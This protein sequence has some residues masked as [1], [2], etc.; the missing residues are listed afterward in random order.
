MAELFHCAAYAQKKQEMEATLGR[1]ARL[2][3][4]EAEQFDL[5]KRIPD[6]DTDTYLAV[7]E[8][9]SR[10]QKEAER[11]RRALERKETELQNMA[12]Q[13]QPVL[14]QIYRES[15]WMADLLAV[16]ESSLQ[17]EQVLKR[18]RA[19]VFFEIEQNEGVA[20]AAGPDIAMT[21]LDGLLM[22]LQELDEEYA[23][24]H[25]GN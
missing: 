14:G 10:M 11:H 21:R 22:Q 7:G 18:R 25:G 2:E 17:G 23:Q 20:R 16:P 19:A 3:E 24:V 13:L 9:I 8:T 12:R 5:Q 15:A 1:I 6:D 4:E